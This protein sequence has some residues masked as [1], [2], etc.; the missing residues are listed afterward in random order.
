MFNQ[1]FFYDTFL[2]FPTTWM[3]YN[4]KQDFGSLFGKML[5]CVDV[6]WQVIMS[7]A[8][9]QNRVVSVTLLVYSSIKKED[10]IQKHT[11]QAANNAANSFQLPQWKWSPAKSNRIDLC[12]SQFHS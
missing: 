10:N 11:Y 8:Q 4:K 1:G 7:E 3:S 6:I 5:F 12:M 2:F 9:V